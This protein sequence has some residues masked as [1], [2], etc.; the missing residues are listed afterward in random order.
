[1]CWI[2]P[3]TVYAGLEVFKELSSVF[4]TPKRKTR[5]S[6]TSSSSVETSPGEK[7]WKQSI[8]VASVS[9]KSNG[10]DEIMEALN[11]TEDVTEKLDLILLK[12]IILDWKMEE[13][14]LTVKGIQD[15]VSL[16]ETE[17]A[18]VQDRENS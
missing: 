17:I 13:L 6:N 5:S 12:L 14:K 3:F 11:L 2:A 1:M 7:R 4:T 9:G 10:G 15:R 18:S 16:M 8:S